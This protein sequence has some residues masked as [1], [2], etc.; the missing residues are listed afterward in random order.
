MAW[1]IFTATGW[2]TRMTG[3]EAIR[4]TH[5]VFA[6]MTLA[7]GLVHAVCFP[8]LTDLVFGFDKVFIPFWDGITRHAVGIIG[9]E[10][11]L[12]AAFTTGARNLFKY[13]TWLRIHQG[14]YIAFVFLVIHSFFGAAANGTLNVVWLGGI[15]L[16]IPAG[17]LC[18]LRFLPPSTLV[19]AGLV[20]PEV[21]DPLGLMEPS[22]EEGK[23]LDVSVNNELCHR[24]GF[25]QAEAPEVFQLTKDGRLRYES[26]PET[27]LSDKTRSAARCCPMRAI[28]LRE[29]SL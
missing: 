21:M 15:T 22:G 6:T 11:M 29:R 4:S 12:A 5:M 25:C 27:R 1:G 10:L 24:Y 23:R 18:G 2:V 28:D 16:F 26:R 13:R 9:F 7:F 3:R 14:T 20:A 19:R 8:L 17:L